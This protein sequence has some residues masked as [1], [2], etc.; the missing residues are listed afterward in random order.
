MD[1][2]QRIFLADSTLREVP[3]VT[4]LHQQVQRPIQRSIKRP[5]PTQSSFQS[6]LRSLPHVILLVCLRAAGG[7]FK[8]SCSLRWT[9]ISRPVMGIGGGTSS[10]ARACSRMAAANTSSGNLTAR[11]WHKELS[12]NQIEGFRTSRICCC[13]SQKRDSIG[14]GSGRMTLRT[15]SSQLLFAR[16][17]S[18]LSLTGLR[19]IKVAAKT[20]V[21]EVLLH[22]TEAQDTMMSQIVARLWIGRTNLDAGRAVVGRTQHHL[23]VVQTLF[24]ACLAGL[25][26]TIFCGLRPIE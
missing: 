26:P 12:G 10:A 8:L 25:G 19:S 6:P 18:Q 9:A 17:G 13:K 21:E 7:G 24:C 23:R 16:S 15:T 14:C 11:I 3:G 20:F 1:R 4:I 22:R 5:V 2:V